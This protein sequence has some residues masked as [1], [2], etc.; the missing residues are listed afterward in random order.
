MPPQG[1]PEWQNTIRS[2]LKASQVENE[3]YRDLIEQYRRL[4][5]HARELKIRNRALLR[6]GG[7]GGEGSTPSPLLAH[8]DA[9][10]TS[11]RS[12]LS[13]V[14]R[15]Q[16]AS[17]NKQLQMA[18][19]L[20]DRDEEVRGLREE[21]RE[22]RDQRD[23]A[24]R[25]ER[26]W[27]ERW[28]VRT[29]DMEALSDEL[30]SQNLEISSLEQQVIDLKTDNA[31]LLQRWI[32]KMNSTAE[33][34]NAAFEEEQAEAREKEKEEQE[35]KERAQT[36]TQA[37]DE[38][39]GDTEAKAKEK[40]KEKKTPIGKTG[41]RS[42][43]STPASTKGKV[44]PVKGKEKPKEAEEEEESQAVE[45]SDDDEDESERTGAGARMDGEVDEW[46][47]LD[48]TP[49]LES[50]N[51]EKDNLRSSLMNTTM[52][53]SLGVLEDEDGWEEARFVEE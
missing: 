48:D 1:P 10:L 7:G 42:T 6:S 16:A 31:Q 52:E 8:L 18:D 30:I 24:Y 13:Q 46:D 19:S 43:T 9:Q 35:A 11:I 2:R 29:K 5:K 14:Y 39:N 45:D 37:D 21:A 38:K 4:A 15:S 12:E 17:Q 49:G 51:K 28:K 27:E 47:M 34:M 53:Q 25:K 41:T 22:L 36:Q 50:Q 3:G 32:D 26:D 33:E 23:N 20:R 44:T 40:E